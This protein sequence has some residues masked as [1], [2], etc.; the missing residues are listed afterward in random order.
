MYVYIYSITFPPTFL[1]LEKADF[2]PALKRKETAATSEE[3]DDNE[4]EEE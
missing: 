4:E 1:V 3:I 2:F